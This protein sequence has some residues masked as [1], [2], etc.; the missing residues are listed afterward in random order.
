MLITISVSPPI[1][2]EEK[3]KP[4][5]KEKKNR[6]VSGGTG[7]KGNVVRSGR[8]SKAIG[9]NILGDQPIVRDPPPQHQINPS[10]GSKDSNPL[11]QTPTDGP[12]HSHRPVFEFPVKV[13]S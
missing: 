4:E 1:F 3:E 12:Q 13:V 8:D 11:A 9:G 2:E 10:P 5:E 7:E 6:K